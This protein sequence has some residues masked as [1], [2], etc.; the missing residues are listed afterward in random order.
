MNRYCRQELQ[1]SPVKG[2]DPIPNG[3]RT[4]I[5]GRA[6]NEPAIVSYLSTQHTTT[7][8]THSS[9]MAAFSCNYLRELSILLLGEWIPEAQ[10]LRGTQDA[11]SQQGS[12]PNKGL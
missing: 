10:T 4:K 2:E 7:L 9:D 6:M 8:L 3:K 12:C 5:R 11:P 1:T